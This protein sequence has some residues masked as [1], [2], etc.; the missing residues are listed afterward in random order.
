MDTVSLEANGNAFE[1][2]KSAKILGVTIRNDLKW[3]DHV[4]EITMKASRRIYLLKQLKR[5]GID[6]KSLILF[7][8]T[9][10]R[11]VLEYAYQALHTNLPAYLSDQIERVQKIV[12]K[13]LFP[14]VSYSKALEDADLKTLFRRRE[15]L[16]S[17]LFKQIVE[18]DQ[19]KLAGL[20]PA[21]N[22]SERY[23]FRTRR[24]FSIP[25]LK[26]KRFRNTFI[27]HFAIKQQL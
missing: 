21:H 3:I 27:M 19:H 9:C 16:C 14:E 6:R 17:S 13:I 18:S 7:Y 5:A 1:I 2:V 12:L 10:I 4:V 8:C 23:N 11:S 22:D 25:N 24:M 26:T 20:L 15:E